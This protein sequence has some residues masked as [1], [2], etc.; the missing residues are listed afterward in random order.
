MLGGALLVVS[1]VILALTGGYGS[2]ERIQLVIVV[3]M[4]FAMLVALVLLRPDWLQMAYG[5]CVPQPLR[6]PEWLLRDGRPE[7]QMIARHSEWVEATLYVG[8]IGGGG[9]DYLAYTSFLRDKG[10]GMA[11]R[12]GIQC[13]VGERAKLR[14]WVRAPLIDCTLSFL[15]VVVFSG[16]FVAS[17]TLLLGPQHQLPSD[18]AFL[19]HQAQFVTRVHPW[20]YVLYVVGVFLTMLGTLYGTL[21]V[22]PTIFR[23]SSMA[24]G[25]G[26]STKEFA[27][28]PNRRSGA[29]LWCGLGALGVLAM[30]FLHQWQGKGAR[31]P[32]LTSI[33]IPAN[34]FTGVF[35]CGITCLCNP[36]MDRTLPQE[37]RASPLL[38]SLNYLAGCLFVAIAIKGAWDQYGMYALLILCGTFVAGGVGAALWNKPHRKPTT[39]A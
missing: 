23:E 36:W 21:E 30:C 27:S 14:Q 13:P 4:L 37:L 12:S 18:Q 26:I 35:L 15:A 33:L 8:V 20:L 10:W 34:L 24:L 39:D 9:Y 1:M 2:L 31:P 19:E 5:L 29:I 22:A 38:V 28:Q 32:G 11:Q 6:Y 25:G 16:V 7:M 17:G 3:C